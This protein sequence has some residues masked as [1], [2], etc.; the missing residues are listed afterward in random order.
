MRHHVRVGLDPLEEAEILQP[1]DDLL[2]RGETVDAVQFLGELRRAFRQAAQIILVADQRE[3]GLLIE[4]ADLRQ[5][6]ALADLEIVEVMRRRDLH[7]A[8]AFFRIGIFVGDDRDLA[9]DQRQDDMLADQMS[10][11][12]HRP[13]ARRRALSPSM[14]SGRVVAT[15]MKVVGSSG[16]KVLPSS[17]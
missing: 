14:V 2:A 15:T 4:H 17:G 6:V 8:R 10:C 5:V 9:A 11:S 16:L 13:D 7:R 3:T 12:A 1:R